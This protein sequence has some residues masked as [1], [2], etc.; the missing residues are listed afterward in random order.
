MYRELEEGINLYNDEKYQ[1][2]LVFFLSVETED[3]IV[4]TEINY[5]TGLSYSRLFEYEKALEYL[6]QVVTANLD[7]AKVY[8]CRLILAVIYA[9]TERTRLAEFELSKL[10]ESGYESAQVYASMAYVAYMHNQVDQAIEQYEK[11][12]ELNPQNSTAMNGLGYILAETER[13]ITKGMLLCKSAIESQPENPAYLDSMAFI[14][15]KMKMPEEA[16]DFIKRAKEKLPDNK[17][18][19]GHYDEIMENTEA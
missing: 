1:E 8:Q 5:Y 12:L 13:N 17:T 10:L 6:E 9:N 18:I 7:I 19:Q 14:Y 11:A 4:Q 3:K 2:A 16:R 15:Y